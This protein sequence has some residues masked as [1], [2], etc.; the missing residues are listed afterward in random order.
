MSDSTLN[1]RITADSLNSQAERFFA[2][3]IRVTGSIVT[4]Q[5]RLYIYDVSGLWSKP[6]R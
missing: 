6:W 1:P 5:D 2:G 4:E 3:F